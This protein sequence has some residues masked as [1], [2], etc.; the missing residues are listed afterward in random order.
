[1]VELL[2]LFWGINEPFIQWWIK[3]GCGYMWLPVKKMIV[4]IV[5]MIVVVVVVEKMW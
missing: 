4:M 1:M 5:M 3:Y 2:L